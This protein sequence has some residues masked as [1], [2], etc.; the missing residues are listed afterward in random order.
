M[1][2]RGRSRW[3][4]WG[5]VG[6][7]FLLIMAETRDTLIFWLEKGG[8]ATAQCQTHDRGLRLSL[9]RQGSI[10]LASW[11]LFVLEYHALSLCQQ[12]T[13]Q[14]TLPSPI[15]TQYSTLQQTSTRP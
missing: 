8:L 4:Y 3:E 1:I 6:H 12:A 15:L 5:I 11:Q 10:L 13:R 7:R 9:S 14:P 2:P